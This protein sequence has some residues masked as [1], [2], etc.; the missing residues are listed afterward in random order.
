MPLLQEVS[1]RARR[2]RPPGPMAATSLF[3][4]A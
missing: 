2:P 1:C 4:C 3:P